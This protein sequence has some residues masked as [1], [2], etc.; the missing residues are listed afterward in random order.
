MELQIS[1]SH[2]QIKQAVAKITEYASE[3]GIS[4]DEKLFNLK[5]AVQEALVN[6][7]VHGNK[8]NEVKG[9][10]VNC[11]TKGNQFVVQIE[12]QGEGFDF[13]LVLNCKGDIYS[14]CGRGIFLIKQSVEHF[15]YLEGGKKLILYF[16]K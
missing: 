2:Y 9:I 13:N 14:H 16:K 10:L 1:S 5:L 6:S 11:F 8:A 4:D 15:E 12:D 3:S 7:M